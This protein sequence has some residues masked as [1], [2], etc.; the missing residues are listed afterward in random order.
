M[1]KL[2]ETSRLQAQVAKYKNDL[3]PLR[4]YPIVSSGVAYNFRIR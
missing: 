2:L 1:V 3:D 4:T